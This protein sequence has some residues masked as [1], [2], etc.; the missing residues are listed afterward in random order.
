MVLPKVDG[1]ALAPRGERVGECAEGGKFCEARRALEV[2]H[3]L[4]GEDPRDEVVGDAVAEDPHRVGAVRGRSARRAPEARAEGTPGWAHP[5]HGVKVLGEGRDVGLGVE[6][7]ALH[8]RRGPGREG[9]EVV[10]E[11]LGREAGVE[12][13][14]AGVAERAL[15][16]EPRV[17][18]GERE[19][20]GP[21]E[22]LGALGRHLPRGDVTQDRAQVALEAV[23]HLDDGEGGRLAQ[24]RVVEAGE[25]EEQRRRVAALGAL[26]ERFEPPKPAPGE[27]DQRV[28][29]RLGVG[30]EPADE[31][32][33]EVVRVGPRDE[34]L[35]AQLRAQ[36]AEERVGDGHRGGHCGAQE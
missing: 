3:V 20:R 24:G 26:T 21:D 33:P 22:G 16:D 5:E 18:G 31:V 10:E 19:R 34:A 7:G 13:L 15:G 36:L 11:D 29:E 27:G 30:R 1:E 9:E 32:A 35:L 6:G 2:A 23:A 8:L 12:G 14:T 28:A 25:V 17:G 4:D